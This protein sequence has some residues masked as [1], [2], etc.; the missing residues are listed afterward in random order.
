M[1]VICAAVCVWLTG[2]LPS[3]LCA[4]S[5]F[6][7][8]LILSMNR[9]NVNLTYYLYNMSRSGAIMED[10][11]NYIY[12][13]LIEWIFAGGYAVLV[14]LY[15]NICKKIQKSHIENQALIDGVQALLRQEIIDFCLRYEGQGAAPVWAKQAE[16]QIYRAY[17]ALGGNDV[18]HA[19]HER[20]MKLPL[21]DNDKET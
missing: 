13:H 12:L 4:K 3:S 14:I 11:I 17:E 2:A 7:A 19:M 5:L 6:G 21:V 18:A 20:F 15:R 8:E 10:L 1:S 9:K 16:E